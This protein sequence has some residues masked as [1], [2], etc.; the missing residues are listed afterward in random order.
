MVTLL[1]KLYADINYHNIFEN[2][3]NVYFKIISWNKKLNLLIK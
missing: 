3:K 2:L 1:I